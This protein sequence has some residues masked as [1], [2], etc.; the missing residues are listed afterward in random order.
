MKLLCLFEN[1]MPPLL[2]ELLTL[3]T[4]SPHFLLC[5]FN[6]CYNQQNSCPTTNRSVGLF[7]FF[8]PM[9][10][11]SQSTLS[12]WSR[13]INRRRDMKTDGNAKNNAFGWYI[14]FN[15]QR[16]LLFLCVDIILFL[17]SCK[18]S[19]PYYIWV[20]V[21]RLNHI[22]GITLPKVLLLR[23]ISPDLGDRWSGAIGCT[24]DQL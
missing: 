5:N 18:I 1:L 19:F 13:Q 24:C 8:Y 4:I 7:F 21:N 12:L 20:L 3:C 16:S 23:E 10:I 17:L 9:R 14:I 11:C 2:C 6:D 15:S 22:W